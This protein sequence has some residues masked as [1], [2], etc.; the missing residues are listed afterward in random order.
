MGIGTILKFFQSEGKI[1]VEREELIIR[2]RGSEILGAVLWSIIE[3]VPSG[4][5]TVSIVVV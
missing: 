4:P 3:E 5:E 2:E 1:S